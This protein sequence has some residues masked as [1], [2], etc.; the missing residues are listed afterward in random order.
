MCVPRVKPSHP[1]R[2]QGS[3]VDEK[4]NPGYLLAIRLSSSPSLTTARAHAPLSIHLAVQPSLV[5]SKA[6]PGMAEALPKPLK[7]GQDDNVC[8]DACGCHG[9]SPKWPTMWLAPGL[10]ARHLGDCLHQDLFMLV[11]FLWPV[12][13][14]LRLGWWRWIWRMALEGAM[15]STS[16]RCQ[17]NWRKT[18]V[19]TQSFWEEPDGSHQLP[20]SMNL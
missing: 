6:V 9:R 7:P 4:Y 17:Q 16:E 20:W 5:H 11:L 18:A 12:G 8:A 19:L 10:H 15:S 3:W 14:I 2:R 1:W 13:I